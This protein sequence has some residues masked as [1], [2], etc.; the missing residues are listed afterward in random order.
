MSEKNQ[1]QHLRLVPKDLTFVAIRPDFSHFG[2]LIDISDGGLRFQFM[3]VPRSLAE[4]RHMALD[5]FV[6]GNGYYLSEVSCKFVHEADVGAA[7][8][9]A[10]VTRHF[11]LQF[12]GLTASQTERLE[13]F[14]EHY[15]A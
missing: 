2:R 7:L 5:L 6:H 11:G 12:K 10:L 13:Y 9:G 15:T 3:G 8:P 4:R 14:F 1:R